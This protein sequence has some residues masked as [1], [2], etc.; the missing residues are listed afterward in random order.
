LRPEIQ[1]LPF[2]PDVSSSQ[3][4]Q[5][6]DNT[7]NMGNKVEHFIKEDVTN[8]PITTIQPGM[9][10]NLDILEFVFPVSLFQTKLTV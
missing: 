9:V 5:R 3:S 2:S 6:T 8:L 10:L 1:T 4:C 7:L